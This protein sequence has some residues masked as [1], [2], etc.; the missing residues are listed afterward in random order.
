MERCPTC[1]AR[2]KEKRVCRRCKTDLGPLLDMERDARKH[3]AEAAEAYK[4]NDYDRMLEHAGRA[5]ALLTTAETTRMLAAACL[6]TGDYS[7][8]LSL[9]KNCPE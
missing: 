7:T 3:Y 9:W 5:R 2:C 1:K 4:T 6:L 8:S